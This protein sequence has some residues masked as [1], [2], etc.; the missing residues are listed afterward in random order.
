MTHTVNR[1]ERGRYLDSVALMRVSR[2]LAA[3][4]GVED[5]SLMMASPSNKALLADAALLTDEGQQAQGNDL[6]IA[7]RASTLEL[8]QAALQTAQEFLSEKAATASASATKARSLA[9]AHGLMPD[10]N[11]ALISLPGDY[12]AH[13]ARRALERGLHVLMFSD[14]VPLE[15]EVQ[16]KRFAHEQG[17]LLMGPDC[18]TAFLAGTPIAFANA[19]PRGGVG[20][21]SASGTGLQE[22]ACLLARAGAGI[23]HGI[24]V[25]G[26]DLDARVGAISTLDALDALGRD[27][28]THTI[29]L[30]SKPPAPEVAALVLER[31]ATIGKPCVVCFLGLDEL[32]LPA[33]ATL[34]RTLRDAAALALGRPVDNAASTPAALLDQAQ[35]ASG[36]RRQVR[37]LFCG[38]TLCAEAQIVFL[39][40]GL[41]VASNAAIPGASQD[42]PHV[43]LDL[44]DDEFTQG[45]PHPML[46]PEIRNDHVRAALAAAET[47]V[48]LVDLV[49]GYGAHDNPAAVLV[50]ALGDA[51]N[52]IP[53]VAS[54]TGTAA[55]PQGYEAQLQILR[56]AGV[57]VAGSNAQA[58]Q[59]AAHLVS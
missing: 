32:A 29:V 18:G 15:D 26:R 49:I 51:A 25:G 35:V 14:N 21:V 50:Q 23:S 41:A 40:A 20:I 13:E 1:V 2:R 39:A 33:N 42:A 24:G 28:A 47:G 38:G 56:A 10:A 27:P 17:L 3:A 19:V 43:F 7:V 58:A 16:L 4:Q 45:R 59:W 5:A 6:V 53:V 54:I 46:E 48:I 30:I 8:A 22:V 44:G 9:G 52:R 12:A 57:L 34:A 31:V 36:N 37:G 11:L 55:D